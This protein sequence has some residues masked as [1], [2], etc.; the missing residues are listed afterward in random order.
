M[1]NLRDLLRPGH[2]LEVEA[3]R[4]FRGRQIKSN[5]H[6]SEYEQLEA[7]ASARGVRLGELQRNLVQEKLREDANPWAKLAL[8]AVLDARWRQGEVLAASL[9]KELTQAKLEAI[10]KQARLGRR[11]LLFGFLKEEE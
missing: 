7:L 3:M 5:Y 8:L 6:E 4:E 10:E 1:G 2:A 11:D 9:R